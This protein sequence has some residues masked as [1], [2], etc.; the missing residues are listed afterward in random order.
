M[1]MH[2]GHAALTPEG[3]A[4]GSIRCAACL[5]HQPGRPLPLPPHS[6]HSRGLMRVAL[7]RAHFG[8]LRRLPR[9]SATRHCRLHLVRMSGCAPTSTEWTGATV[10]KTFIDFFKSK[11]HTFWPSSSV[12]PVNDPTLLFANAGESG[13]SF[14]IFFQ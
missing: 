5:V 13:S 8:A 11:Q 10:R 7:N 3:G 9:I 1:S 4:G 2:A 12:V 14:I 6:I